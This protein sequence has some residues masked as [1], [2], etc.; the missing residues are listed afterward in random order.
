METYHISIQCRKEAIFPAANLSSHPKDWN[1]T[2][3][4]C[5]DTSPEGEN[6]MPGYHASRLSSRHNLPDLISTT[7]RKKYVLVFAKIR[8]SMANGFTGI[9]LVR[10]WVAWR[11]L[12]L[13]RRPSLIYEYTS[14][15]TDPQ[16]HCQTKTTEEDI[17]NM[18]KILLNESLE[19][20]SAV[21]LSPFCVLNRPPA[22]SF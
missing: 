10:C 19:D 21:G 9:D 1:H 17:N 22:V 11:I 8:A 15:L 2:W 14:E 16:R 18:T 7:A 20:C 5:Q 12:P 13:R 4:Y 6:P 3:F